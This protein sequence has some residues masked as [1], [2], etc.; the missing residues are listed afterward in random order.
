M[1]QSVKEPQYKPLV[2]SEL[3]VGDH[4]VQPGAFGVQDLMHHALF[5]GYYEGYPKVLHYYGNPYMYPSLFSKMSCEIRFDSI[6]TLMRAA[7]AMETQLYVQRHINPKY[8][9]DEAV[10]RVIKRLGENQY[11]LFLNNCEHLV[12]W[13]IEDYP[14]SMQIDRL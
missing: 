12:N 10:Q 3:Q 1:V 13:A 7:A 11:N 14:V 4:I 9:G 8:S 6:N 2:L 5:A